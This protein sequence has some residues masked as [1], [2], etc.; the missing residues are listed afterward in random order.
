VPAILLVSIAFVIGGAVPSYARTVD[1]KCQLFAA[2]SPTPNVTPTPQAVDF[3]ISARA[4]HPHGPA[5]PAKQ[6]DPATVTGTLHA[7]SAYC[8]GNEFAGEAIGRLKVAWPDSSTS[9]LR[10]T[11]SLATSGTL[12]GL[13]LLSGHVKSGR[14]AGDRVKARLGPAGS[15]GACDATGLYFFFLDS[16]GVQ[17][18]RQLTFTHP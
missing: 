15:D 12:Q 10:V 1:A 13:Y 14:F 4:Q 6:T 7:D 2:V 17:G 16:S 18:S 8:V 3:A 9:T 11:I 5:C